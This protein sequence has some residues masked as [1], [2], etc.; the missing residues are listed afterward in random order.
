MQK[1]I[2]REPAVTCMNDQGLNNLHGNVIF[3]IQCRLA[4]FL[5]PSNVQGGH[6]KG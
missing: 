5:D 3:H 4:L 1:V 2:C 6:F